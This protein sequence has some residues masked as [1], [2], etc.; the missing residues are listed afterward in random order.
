MGLTRSRAFPQ[1]LTQHLTFAQV[2]FLAKVQNKGQ[3]FLRL[4]T[5]Y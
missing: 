5:A 2:A 1:K 4:K 3:L